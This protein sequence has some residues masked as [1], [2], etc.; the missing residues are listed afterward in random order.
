MCRDTLDWMLREMRGPEGG[1]YSALDADSEGVEGRY[2][3]WTV[4]E[5]EEVLG[6][7]AAEAIR[8]L[9]ASEEG[10]FRRSAPSRAG[11]ERAGGPRPA[12][13]E[14]ATR[15]RIRTRLLE[16]RERRTR[17]G[18]DDKRL[19][20]W[21]ALA[22]SALADAGSVL[23]ESRYLD[24]AKRAPSSSCATCATAMAGCCAPTAR[25]HPRAPP[26]RG[27]A[28][29]TPERTWRTTPSCWKPC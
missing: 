5:L 26:S 12:T 21:N 27:P 23:G 16:A 7:D 3:V 15:E 10:N 24:A 18:L 1:F 28:A 17:P 9:G 11:A 20:S 13:P 8:W 29:G 6:E 22:I 4:A 25:D 2:Y 19:C 14:A